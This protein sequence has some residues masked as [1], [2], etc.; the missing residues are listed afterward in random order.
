MSLQCNCKR[1]SNLYGKKQSCTS[2]FKDVNIGRE[3]VCPDVGSS[4]PLES[5]DPSSWMRSQKVPR[6]CGSPSRNLGHVSVCPQKASNGGNQ[7]DGERYGLQQGGGSS[8]M[9]S[10]TGA[11][12]ANNRCCGCLDPKKEEDWFNSISRQHGG[13]HN[14]E[15]EEASSVAPTPQAAETEPECPAQLNTTQDSP[16]VFPG[17]DCNCRSGA[18]CSKFN[19][20]RQYKNEATQP[21]GWYNDLTGCAIGNRPVRGEHDQYYKI[22]KTLTQDR[23]NLTD[24]KFDCQQ[25][26]WCSKCM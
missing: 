8:F 23:G 9:Y 13:G 16:S 19:S 21:S 26:Y 4:A 20:E 14:T 5:Q 1:F 3:Y 24:R 7:Q 10:A 15:E 6:S 2:C 18:T 17:N 25:P 12:T 11:L 22:P